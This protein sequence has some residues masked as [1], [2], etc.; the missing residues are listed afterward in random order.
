[1]MSAKGWMLL[2]VLVG[3]VL[4]IPFAKAQEGQSFRPPAPPSIKICN[5]NEI[6]SINWNHPGEVRFVCHSEDEKYVSLVIKS[7]CAPF[8]LNDNGDGWYQIYCKV[9]E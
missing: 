6:L 5:H 4:M 3:M 1:M 7:D 2:G 9:I 8:Y